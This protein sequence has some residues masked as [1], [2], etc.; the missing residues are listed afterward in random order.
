MTYRTDLGLDRHPIDSMEHTQNRKSEQVLGKNHDPA[1]KITKYILK[2]NFDK[3]S[4]FYNPSQV[5]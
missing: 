1:G 4:N 3:P 5:S 2:E